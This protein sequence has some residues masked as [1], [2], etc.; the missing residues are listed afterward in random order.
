MT[1]RLPQR[2]SLPL[3]P[4][5][6]LML[7]VLYLIGEAIM[8]RD[9]PAVTHI[10]RGIA[11]MVYSPKG[12]QTRNELRALMEMHINAVQTAGGWYDDAPADW[13]AQLKSAVF[14]IPPDWSPAKDLYPDL[15]SSHG[16]EEDLP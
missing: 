14:E 4:E 12:E 7:N 9:T 10:I 16:G 5:T 3:E 13:L 11:K 1:D 6:A 2:I 8:R 15:D